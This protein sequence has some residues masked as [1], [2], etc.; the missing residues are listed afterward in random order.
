MLLELEVVMKKLV[1]A[2]PWSVLLTLL[3]VTQPAL[4][5]APT[6]KVT[7]E[8]GGLTSMIDVTNPQLLSSSHIWGATFSMALDPQ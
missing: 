5:K 8:G 6:V 2:A 1:F 3:C 7:I 4:A